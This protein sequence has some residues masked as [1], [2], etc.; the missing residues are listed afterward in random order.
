MSPAIY[1]NKSNYYCPY[2]NNPMTFSYSAL[3]CNE[4]HLNISFQFN[5]IDMPK[6]NL[7]Y[8]RYYLSHRIHLRVQVAENFHEN[9]AIIPQLTLWDSASAKLLINNMNRSILN[10]PID[11]LQIKIQ[12]LLYFI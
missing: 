11:Q 7:I 8:I 9:K 5:I 2:C 12:N 4:R 10:L 1:N 6:I 3:S